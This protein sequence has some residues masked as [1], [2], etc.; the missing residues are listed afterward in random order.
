MVR[1]SV[2][3]NVINEAV[4]LRGRLKHSWL[5]NQVCNKTVDD[6]VFLWQRGKWRALEEEFAFRAQETLRLADE[7]VTGFSPAQLVETL[8]PLY[9]LPPQTRENL[10]QAVHDAYL[11]CSGAESLAL[12]LRKAVMSMEDELKRFMAVWH[13]PPTP[14]NEPELRAGWHSLREKADG[15]LAV[16][17]QLPTGIVLP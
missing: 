12:D 8:A 14:E 3:V 16:F 1:K 9:A 15:L 17:S 10:K 5:E 7:M 11:E 13:T 6:V 2:K 4:L